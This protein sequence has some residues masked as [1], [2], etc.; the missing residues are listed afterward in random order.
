MTERVGQSPNAHLFYDVDWTKW[1]TKRGYAASDI[2]S[3]VW[4]VP[5]PLVKTHQTL[6]LGVA[7]VFVRNVPRDNKDYEITSTINMPEPVVGIGN[8]TDEFKFV[9]RNRQRT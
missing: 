9:V 6:T 2:I 5:T 8:V 1:L 4:T 3:I 7:R